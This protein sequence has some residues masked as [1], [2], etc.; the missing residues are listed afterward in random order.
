[1][2]VGR[3]VVAGRTKEGM[4]YLAY[5]VSS[6]S[7]P[8]RRIVVVEDRAMVV[9][10]E[11][12][13]PTDNPYVSY[14]CLRRHK[15]TVLVANGSHVD[16]AIDK[17]SLGYGVRD[18]LALSLLAL[19]YEHDRYNTPRI[20]AGL[21]GDSGAMFLGIVAE[22]RLCVER[23]DVTSGQALLLA[24]YEANDPTPVTLAGATPGALCDAVYECSYEHPVTALACMLHQ[25][26]LDI[27]AR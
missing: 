1:M 20:A 4:P 2:Y 7:F 12:A 17:I 18:A 3:F 27:A 5:R 6:R 14:N 24:T 10:T 13:P 25:G 9:P 22:G 26:R 11:D 19:D 21:E 8:N 16:P 15:G 23:V